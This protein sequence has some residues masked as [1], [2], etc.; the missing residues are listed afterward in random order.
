[1][2]GKK[3]YYLWGTGKLAK[4]INIEYGDVLQKF[5]IIGYIDNNQSLWGKN[6]AGKKVYRPDIL[7][8]ENEAYLVIMNTFQREIVTQIVSSFSFDINRI[9]DNFLQKVQT[10]ARYQNCDDNEIRKVVSWL[11]DNPLGVFNYPFVKKYRS[12][13]CIVKYDYEKDMFY[14]FYDDKKMYLSRK[15]NSYEKAQ[16]YVNWLYMEQDLESP[17]R[18][19]Y[20]V[21]EKEENLVVLDAGAAEG[22]FSLALIDRAKRIYVVEPDPDWIEALKATFENYEEK[23][24]IIEKGLSSYENNSLTTVD[25]VVNEPIDILKMDIEG[26]EYYALCGAER[27]LSQ[28]PNLKC[29]IA[30]YHQEFAYDA[31]RNFFEQKNYII[32]ASKGYMWFPEYKDSMRAP[33]LRKGIIRARKEMKNEK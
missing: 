22:F 23:I 12:I 31:I 5:D 6:F 7:D 28:S 17:H 16:Q 30:T 11:F 33:V 26:E 13:D 25:N 21:E 2:E 10:I 8:G 15:I 14:S 27:T 24:V 29:Y 9:E 1:M 3:K 19:M 18:Y 32:E 20:A 4:L